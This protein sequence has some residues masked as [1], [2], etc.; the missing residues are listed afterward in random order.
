MTDGVEQRVDGFP[1]RR[2]TSADVAREAG[3]SR[4]T[5]SY[6]LNNAPNRSIAPATRAL[7]LDTAARLGHVPHASARALRLGRTNVVL[8]LV[9]D[10]TFGYIADQVLEGLDVAL[11]TRGYVLLVNRY[12]EDVRQ[13]DELWRLVD[14]A[15][16]VSMS[17][18]SVP[19]ASSIQGFQGKLVR[20]HN[21]M[22]RRGAGEMQAEYL[23]SRGHRHLGYAYPVDPGVQRVARERLHG[24][25]RA[26]S[27]LGIPAPAVVEVD[28]ADTD[29]A[30]VAIKRWREMPGP[31]TAICA[32][33]DEIAIMLQ[34]LMSS[35]MAQD[36]KPL[37]VIGI[38]DIPLARVG[39]TTIAID[40]EQATSR[41]VEMVVAAL[42][43]RPAKVS[44]KSVLRL[45]V[46]DSA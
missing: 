29:T 20:G 41:L 39:I 4:A 44:H 32:H 11:A 42:E 17:G 27:R 34:L 24:T 22:N 9:R 8:A 16:V 1:A 46:R 28:K 6:V 36:G 37:A 19:E 7:V 23:F 21:L 33:N 18:L 30:A 45:V 3:V 5:V 14:P 10:F 13:L 38:D 2:A 43:N 31:I 26:C 25:R 40:V 35:R 15:V 12:S